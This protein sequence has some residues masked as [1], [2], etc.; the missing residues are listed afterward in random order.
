ML[1]FTN[2]KNLQLLI[3]VSII[4]LSRKTIKLIENNLCYVIELY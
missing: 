1:R 2:T 4:L 3:H